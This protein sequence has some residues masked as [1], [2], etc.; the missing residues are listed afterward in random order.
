MPDEEYAFQMKNIEKKYLSTGVVANKSVDFDGK[1]GEVHSLVGENG[2]GKTTLM[3]VLSGFYSPDKGDIFIEGEKFKFKSPKSAIKKGIGMVHQERHLIP[4]HTVIENILLGHGRDRDRLNLKE[5]ERKINEICNK[6]S[7]D[8]DLYERLENL[9]ASE[10]QLVEI[11]KVLFHDAKI[12]I[13]DEPAS[14]LTPQEQEK[15]LESVKGLAEDGAC[16]ILISHKLPIVMNV[17]DRITVL[18]DGNVVNTVTPEMTSYEELANMMVGKDEM[19]YVEREK[20]KKGSEILRVDDLSALND[21]GQEAFN[22][23]FTVHE[24]E[25]FT[26]VGV[27]GNGQRELVETVAGLRKPTGGKIM[28]R[29]K[30]IT[31]FSIRDRIEIGVEYL[32]AEKILRGIIVDFDLSKNF[33]MNRHRDRDYSKRG[34]IDWD[35]IKKSC[36]ESITDFEVKASGIGTMA[37]HL[38]GGNI[39]KLLLAR[40][41]THCKDLLIAEDPTQGLDV[42]AANFT[43]ERLIDFKEGN[44]GVLLVT[45]NLDEA[46]EISDRIAPIYEGEIQE[47]I[48]A[49]EASKEKIGRLI[50]GSSEWVE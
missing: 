32:P 22:V 34:I 7:F 44:K 37:G 48:P 39:Q 4:S 50:T 19:F 21:K 36:E 45:G 16:V 29:D 27:S 26:V 42:R 10:K 24:N 35:M 46:L 47:V 2:S 30:D 8:L 13:L 1:Y 6:Y 12:I 17:S 49:E 28:L 25:I 23:S 33:A 40:T 41:L 20:A 3:L 18:R 14:V 5:A 43:R 15:F 11:I 38:S 9:S 31:N